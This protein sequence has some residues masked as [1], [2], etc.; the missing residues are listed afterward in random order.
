MPNTPRRKSAFQFPRLW[1]VAA[2][3][4]MPSN[5]SWNANCPWRFFQGRSK[6]KRHVLLRDDLGNSD[7]TGKRL[8]QLLLRRQRTTNENKQI[9]L[10]DT[11]MEEETREEGAGRAET[12]AWEGRRLPSTL[13][14]RP[15]QS[16]FQ[17]TKAGLLSSRV[18]LQVK[19][20]QLS[21]IFLTV[22]LELF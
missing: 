22:L 1:G 12:E 4:N 19:L 14:C 16:P 11:N 8:S 5:H 3:K 18:K 7:W 15:E 17:D 20:L 9:V 6:N 13:L 10:H 2:K 21:Y